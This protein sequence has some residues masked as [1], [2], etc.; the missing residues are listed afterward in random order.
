MAVANRRGQLDLRPH[1]FLR[2]TPGVM[3]FILIV[4]ILVVMCSSCR[5]AG[6]TIRFS[7][8]NNCTVTVRDSDTDSNQGKTTPIDVKAQGIPGG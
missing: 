5:S 1:N 4:V 8:C 3:L 7:H 6:P 2:H